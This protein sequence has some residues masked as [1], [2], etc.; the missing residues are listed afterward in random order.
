VSE[1]RLF[2]FSDQP[3]PDVGPGVKFLPRTAKLKHMFIELINRNKPLCGSLQDEHIR[4]LFQAAAGHVNSTVIVPLKY[5][6]W[7]GL[8]ALGSQERGRYGRGFELDMIRF[9]FSIVG[10]RLDRILARQAP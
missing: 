1:F 7:E 4:V 2:V 3:D 9:L 5:A 6:R 8:A 10:A